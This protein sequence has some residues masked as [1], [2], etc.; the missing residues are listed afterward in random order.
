MKT[1]KRFI[2]GLFFGLITGSL[3]TLLFAP[4]EGSELR[5]K[6]VTRFQEMSSQFKQAAN[7]KKAELE[8]EIN[9]YLKP[10]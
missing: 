7:Q 9:Q 6:I 1:F 5:K 8:E 3:I 4:E 10:K 2:Q